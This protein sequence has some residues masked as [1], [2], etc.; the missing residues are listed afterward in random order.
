[1]C[2]ARVLMYMYTQM[3]I[4]YIYV[5]PLITL[6]S[7]AKKTCVKALHAHSLIIKRVI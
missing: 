5:A 3:R 7:T 1:M 4:Q 2:M 6:P